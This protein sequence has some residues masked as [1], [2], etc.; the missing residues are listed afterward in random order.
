MA[1]VKELHETRVH[2]RRKLFV[3]ERNYVNLSLVAKTKPHG[4]QLMHV[5]LD[6]HIIQVADEKSRFPWFNFRPDPNIRIDP[7]DIAIQRGR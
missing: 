1:L 5:G 4:F 3:R 2:S 7:D 6:N